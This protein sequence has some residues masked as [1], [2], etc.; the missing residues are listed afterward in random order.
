MSVLNI[1][2]PWCGRRINYDPQCPGWKLRCPKCRWVSRFFSDISDANKWVLKRTVIKEDLVNFVQHT[3]T[4]S[5]DSAL[6]R[7]LQKG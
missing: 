4:G 7:G 6:P 5:E 3:V 1:Q 2:C